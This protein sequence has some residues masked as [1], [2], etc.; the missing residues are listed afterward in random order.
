[1][2]RIPAFWKKGKKALVPF[3]TAGFPSKSFTPEIVLA[4][5]ESGADMV[6]LGVPFSD[7]LA[8]G[9]TIQT[10]SQIA[11]QNGVR[12]GDI[13]RMAEQ[14]R[15]KSEIPLLLM[16]YFNPL[17]AYGLERFAKDASTAGVD[18]LI[19]PDLPPE[20]GKELSK[21]CRRRNLSLVYLIAPT[22]PPERISKIASASSDFSYCVSL[23]GVTGARKKTSAELKDFLLSVRMKTKKPFVVG[24]G[25]STPEQVREVGRFS[26]GVVVGSALVRTFLKEKN[27]RTA[28]RKVCSLVSKMAGGLYGTG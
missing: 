16:G 8:D 26:D 19:V 4:L 13:F 9:P 12:L 14:I 28:L 23:T 24:F 25:L 15:T 27:N 21:N 1:M 17:F 2:N 22:T 3:V 20:E 5:T 6:E 10:S 7:P 18:G 11:L